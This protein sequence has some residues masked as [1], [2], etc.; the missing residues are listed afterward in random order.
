MEEVIAAMQRNQLSQ[1]LEIQQACF[2]EKTPQIFEKEMQMPTMHYLCITKSGEVVG[3]VGFSVIVDEAEIHT[4][5]VHPEHQQK[6]FG[7]RL[8]EYVLQTLQAQGVRKVFLEVR[9]DN[10]PA[11]KM[12]TKAGFTVTY[13]RKKYYGTKDA[14]I[15]E[16]N[17]S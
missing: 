17:L 13:I 12:Y 2:H 11:Q 3:Y 9:E 16:K 5:A 7:Q 8:L 14:Y 6:G 10:I 15:M 4:I 1:V